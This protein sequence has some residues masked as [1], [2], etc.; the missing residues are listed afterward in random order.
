MSPSVLDPGPEGSNG[1][2]CTD[3]A[4]TW[5]SAEVTWESGTKVA[6]ASDGLALVLV[7]IY[8]A[9]LVFRLLPR[10]MDSAEIIYS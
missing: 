2:A 9:G 4:L 8:V 3:G 1:R 6:N 10:V 7:C 5:C